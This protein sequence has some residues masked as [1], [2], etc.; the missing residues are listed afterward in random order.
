MGLLFAPCV[1]LCSLLL[2]GSEASLLAGLGFDAVA[3]ALALPV[4]SVIAA[5]VYDRVPWISVAVAIWS[6]L[7][8]VAATIIVWRLTDGQEV[9]M[10]LTSILSGLGFVHA[11]TL[12][13]A[14]RAEPVERAR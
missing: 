13:A 1:L 7:H 2:D 4:A 14:G 11:V 12:Y 3:L 10:A 5:R 6:S 9:A 8:H